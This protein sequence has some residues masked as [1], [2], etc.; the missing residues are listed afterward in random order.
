[1]T[2]SRLTIVQPATSPEI[3]PASVNQSAAECNVA[4]VSRHH[5]DRT[6]SPPRTNAACS[7]PAGSR[8]RGTGSAGR[9]RVVVVTRPGSAPNLD[10]GCEAPAVSLVAPGS[11]QDPRDADAAAGAR[12]EARDLA[13]ELQPPDPG[14]RLATGVG[15]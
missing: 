5:S 10:G 1:M 12:A 2:T 3:R 15:E 7:A 6:A 11:E 4:G 9:A 13:V 14:P 8:S